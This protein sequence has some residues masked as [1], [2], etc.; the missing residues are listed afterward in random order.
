MKVHKNDKQAKECMKKCMD[1]KS[2]TK[3][4]DIE[5]KDTVLIKQCYDNKS[6]AKFNLTSSHVVRLKLSM[7]SAGWSKKNSI[8]NI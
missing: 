1:K 5:I 3:N 8:E 6:S 2:H 7:I 4:L